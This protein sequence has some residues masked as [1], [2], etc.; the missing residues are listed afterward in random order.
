MCSNIAVKTLKYY[1]FFVFFAVLA[2]LS[3]TS[4]HYMSMCN[5]KLSTSVNSHVREPDAKFYFDFSL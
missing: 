3:D 4:R 2:F 5:V 1:C